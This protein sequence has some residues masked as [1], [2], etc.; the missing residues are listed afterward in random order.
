MPGAGNG[1]EFG[2]TLNDAEEYNMNKFHHGMHTL[3]KKRWCS[4]KNNG[5][6]VGAR[7]ELKTFSTKKAKI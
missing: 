5:Q 4:I 2:Q 1:Q 7:R 6:M 3:T